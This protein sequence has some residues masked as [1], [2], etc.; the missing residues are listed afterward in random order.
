MVKRLFL[1]LLVVIAS[2]FFALNASAKSPELQLP[3]DVENTSAENSTEIV[4]AKKTTV[5]VVVVIIVDGDGEII[6][7][8]VGVG[9]IN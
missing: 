9:I 4:T 1:T 5:V 2:T 8:G 7:I 3:I 6:A